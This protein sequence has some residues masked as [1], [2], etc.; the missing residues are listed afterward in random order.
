MKKS[1]LISLTFFA[2]MGIG[3]SAPAH[4]GIHF[5]LGFGNMPLVQEER[6]LEPCYV[7]EWC[8]CERVIVRSPPERY[9]R[10]V[11]VG[12]RRLYPVYR[13]RVRERVVYPRPMFSV[14][15]CN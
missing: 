12:E 1:L 5:S 9:S 6:Y 15:I 3:I 10:H 7:E 4:A 8:P 14:G 11:L 13:E 2:L